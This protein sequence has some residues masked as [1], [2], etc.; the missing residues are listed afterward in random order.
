MMNTNLPRLLA[1]VAV[2]VSL[3]AQLGCRREP[4]RWNMDVA[5]PLVD[6]RWG[7]E[8]LLG[9]TLGEIE[10][11]NPGVLRFSGQVG[12]VALEEL[13]RLPDTLVENI[14]TPAFAGGP[15]E[16]PPGAVLL[17]ENQDIVFQG[18][19][20]EFTRMTLEE[21]LIQ[22][23][24]R[25]KTNGYVHLRYD[26]PSVTVGGEPVVLDL[27]LPPSLDGGSQTEDGTIDLAS[28]VI[29]F[30]GASG[31]EVNRIHSN[32][33]IGTPA[34]IDYTALVYGD[35]S[36]SVEMLF[37]GLRVREVEGYFGQIQIDLNES[38]PLFDVE[39]FPT[40]L[41]NASPSRAE[42]TLHNTMGA[43][44]AFW[45]ESL[46]LDGIA[47]EHPLMGQEQVMARADWS[48]V[49][50]SVDAWSL[51]LLNCTPDV[52]AAIGDLPGSVSV[53]GGMA[54]NPLGDVT[55]GHDYL[56]ASDPPYV[57]LDLELPLAVGIQGLVMR[58][59]LMLSPRSMPGFVG[60]L[61]LR[62]SHDFPV[63]CS[64]D[65]QFL[66]TSVD[67]TAGPP[68]SAEMPVGSEPLE[69]RFPVEA[70]RLESGGTFPIEV[71]FETD[72]LV[73]FT[74]LETVRVQLAL[75]WRYEAV[76]E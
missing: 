64:V 35:D 72:G 20:Q 52:F 65:A 57:S 6:V 2:L 40:G 48:T 32:L 4:T 41:V 74:G 25:S 61:V 34:D 9:D 24:V 23:H 49:P 68:F 47:I 15:F 3:T 10:V 39:R 8:A 37:T 11:G 7:W 70:K 16:V 27:V 13:T 42:L 33:L 50:P 22:Y 28:A 12:E 55:A 38:A 56:R 66:P 21:G 31:N 63:Q 5:V 45:F 75:E 18:I 29:D 43:D 30:T 54:L 44:L 67:L 19:E 76:V 60:E 46:D 1:T 53:T 69:W 71:R 73:P 62:V 36:I 26:F 14:L 59:E 51:D 58:D 17:D